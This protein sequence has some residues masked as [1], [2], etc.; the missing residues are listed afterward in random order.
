MGRNLPQGDL[1]HQ[2]LLIGYSGPR[3]TDV[4]AKDAYKCRG[5][6]AK[7]RGKLA[8][9]RGKLAKYQGKLAKYQRISA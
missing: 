3:H 2:V 8:K 9:Y 7:F 5:K 1:N 6:L 4:E